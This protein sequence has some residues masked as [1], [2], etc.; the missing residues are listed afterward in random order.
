MHFI[1]IFEVIC[2]VTS[3]GWT[4]L[5]LSSILYLSFDGSS[6]TMVNLLLPVGACPTIATI[7]WDVVLKMSLTQPGFPIPT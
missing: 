4:A 6:I 7:E 1:C 3:T 5:E 2:L